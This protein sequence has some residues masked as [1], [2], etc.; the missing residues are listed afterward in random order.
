MVKNADSV[1]FA[2]LC[3][4]EQDR[5]IGDITVSKVRHY[6]E[7]TK[8]RWT[9]SAALRMCTVVSLLP[10]EDTLGKQNTRKIAQLLW[11]LMLYVCRT[12]KQ[13]ELLSVRSV[14]FCA[15]ETEFSWHK[16][17]TCPEY[18]QLSFVY[19]SVHE[20]CAQRFL[21]HDTVACRSPYNDGR[22]KTKNTPKSDTFS[23][24]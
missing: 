4:K 18:A 13:E 15:Q 12:W 2:F 6:C 10:H 23:V 7:I 11:Y 3:K 21:L 20:T 14:P 19:S 8:L 9:T 17:L 5:L 22:R 24:L 1:L 16:S